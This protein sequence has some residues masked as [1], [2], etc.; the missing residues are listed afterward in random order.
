MSRRAKLKQFIFHDAWTAEV[1]SLS[2]MRRLAVRMLRVTRLIV[3]GFREDDLPVRAAALTFS[4]LISLVPVLAIVFAVLKGLGAGE[5]ALAR[6]HTMIDVM[7]EQFQLFIEQMLE[8]V[9]RTNFWALGWVGVLILFFTVVQVLSSVESTFNRVWGVTRSR[10]VWRRIANYVSVTVIVPVLIM[11]GFAA[12]ASLSS[13]AVMAQVGTAAPLLKFGLGLTPLLAVMV[14]FFFLFV[15]VPNTLVKVRPALGGA[16]IAGIL[17]ILW[18]KLYINLQFGVVRY[19]AIYGTFASVPIF[20]AWLYVCWVII[21]I[22]VEI[23]FAFQ[24]HETFHMERSA[25]RASVTSRLALVLVVMRGAAEAFV[26]G[27]GGFDAGELSQSRRVPVRLV[28]DTLRRLVEGGYLAQV[29]EERGR[30]VLLRPP[31]SIGLKDLV[32]LIA[33]EGAGPG[34]FG[35]VESDPVIA[36]ALAGISSGLHESLEGRTVRDLLGE[37]RV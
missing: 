35:L 21:L 8:I 26:Q 28:L 2:G 14:A 25:A 11:S 27:R 3:K 30:Y 34:E 33:E 15:F 10:G 4:V 20:L 23:A 29:S 1:S 6:L 22:G 31:E 32:D 12:T 9:D 7:P 24:N 5:D 19:N 16:L 18:Q 17:W 13:E 36:S 37:G